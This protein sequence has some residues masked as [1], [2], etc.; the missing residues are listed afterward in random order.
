MGLVLISVCLGR[1]TLT[2][3]TSRARGKAL[4]CGQTRRRVVGQDS[5]SVPSAP[6]F[7]FV[8]CRAWRREDTPPYRG[9]GAPPRPK[10]NTPGCPTWSV[11]LRSGR[12]CP[13]A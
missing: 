13:E 3:V 5:V 6:V 4:S 7:S 12:P 2:L 11:E 8:E 9:R 10:E 1:I